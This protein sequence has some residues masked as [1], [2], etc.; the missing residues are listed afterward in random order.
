MEAYGKIL[1]IAM[2][3]FLILVLIEKWYGWMKGKDTVRQNDMISSL[4]SGVTNVT[5]DV[6]GIGLVIISYQW[7]V[8]KIALVHFQATGV[9]YV[10]AFFAI[11]FA[12]YWVHRLQH[13]YNLFWNAHIIHHSSEEFNLA[14]ALRQTIS[15]LIKVA[16]IF[17]LPAALLGVPTQV[18]ALVAPLHLF[19]QFWYHTQHI[20]RLGFLEKIIVTPSHHRVH[21]AINPEYLDKNYSQIFIFWDKLFGTYQEEMPHVPPVYGVT[22]PV[23]TWNPIKINFM[24]VWLL[25]QDAW[26]TNS[27]KDKLRIWFMPLGWRPADVVEK[28]PVYKINDVYNYEKY[29][30]KV[31]SAVIVWSWVQMLFMLLMV[32]Y[33]FGNIAKIGSPGIFWYGAFIFLMVYAY[34]ELLDKNRFA[35]LWELAKNSLGA[36]LIWK[37]GGWFGA[38]S[39][40]LF[41]DTLVIFYLA[42]SSLIVIYFCL[43]LSPEPMRQTSVSSAR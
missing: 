14:C 18:I 8:D 20:G 4:S 37:N 32:S 17:L 10:I 13:E 12:G 25:I 1:L 27:L 42:I 39:V 9:V 24:H 21:H 29:N 41:A 3:A 35:Y 34:T 6:L 36:Y 22:R 43:N 40:F 15:T 26:H 33:L 16:A 19:A 28:Y 2:P 30:P 38:N 7:M 11:D 31:S 5:K 23:Q